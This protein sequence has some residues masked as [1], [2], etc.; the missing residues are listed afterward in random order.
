MLMDSGITEEVAI[1]L[2]RMFKI[3][4]LSY[5]NH[6]LAGKSHPQTQHMRRA[7]VARRSV[8]VVG[9]Q[10]RETGFDHL[11]RIPR[12]N[13]V[14]IGLSTAAT[15]AT[16]NFSIRVANPANATNTCITSDDTTEPA[17]WEAT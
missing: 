4:S 16:Q 14:V 11:G 9:G 7:S 2:E 15:A 17:F 1:N 6:G 3:E 8:F 5:L 10:I 12:N 13:N